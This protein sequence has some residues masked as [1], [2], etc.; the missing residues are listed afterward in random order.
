M[1]KAIA[2]IQMDQKIPEGH[3]T[4]LRQVYIGHRLRNFLAAGLDFNE[5]IKPKI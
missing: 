1:A 2:R 4:Q 5:K 3:T